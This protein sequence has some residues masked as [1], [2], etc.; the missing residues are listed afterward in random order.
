MEKPFYRWTS[1]E[2]IAHLRKFDRKTKIKI[3]A[4]SGGVILFLVFVFWPAWAI[5]PQLKDRVDSLR[6]RLLTAET[7]IRQEPKMIEQRMNDEAFVKKVRGRLL[8]AEEKE[9]VPGI[10]AEIAKQSKV[11]VLEIT[12]ADQESQD[13]GNPAAPQLEGYQ[14]MYYDMTVEGGFHELATFV[15]EIENYAKILRVEEFSITA[16]EESPQSHLG[17]IRVTAFFPGGKNA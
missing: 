7:Q 11:M 6:G 14:A 17:G 9:R 8:K 4:A 15:S 16:R 10:L 1:Q 13:T 5:R 2:L 3:G 12:P